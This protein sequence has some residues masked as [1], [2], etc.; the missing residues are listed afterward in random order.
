[1][2]LAVSNI[3]WPAG[4][5]RD[6]APIL[7]EHRAEG[8][9]I[10]P[11]KVWPRP[12]EV[13]ETEVQ[14]YR[15]S[16]ERRDVQVVALQ[17]LLFGRPDLQVFAGAAARQQTLEYLK[18]MIDLAASLGARALVFG[19]P[20]NRHVGAMAPAEAKAIAVA[21]FRALGD[22]AARRE[23]VFCVEANP[24]AYGC[25]FIT[26]TAEAADLVMRVGSEGFGLHIDTGGMTL[27]GEDPAEVLARPGLSWRHFHI[28]EP[29]LDPIG[30]GRS[31]HRAI[32]DALRR[33]RYEGWV[34][35][36]M[37]EPAPEGAWV[38]ALRN[39]LD[40]TR[41]TYRSGDE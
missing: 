10:A 9:E 31:D 23:V 12:L 19:S 4:L 33:R 8:V 39:T 20:K 29:N 18:G 11:T 7:A 41:E 15:E 22:H 35:I 17:A 13:P 1:M 14:R 2:R 24:T 6:A 21:L 28:S 40:F 36:E 3:A 26:T 30:R 38:D 16:W 25:D 34:S 32:A 5:D 27:S 37:K